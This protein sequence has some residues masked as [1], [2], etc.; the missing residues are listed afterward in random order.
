MLLAAARNAANLEHNS[1]ALTQFDELRTME[2]LNDA[3]R[4]EYEGLLFRSG[5]ADKAIQEL[6]PARG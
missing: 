5:Q 2:T 4:L 3:A 1:V 6:P